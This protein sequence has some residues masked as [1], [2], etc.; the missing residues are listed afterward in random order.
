MLVFVDGEDV[1]GTLAQVPRCGHMG[2]QDEAAHLVL[3]AGHALG[4]GADGRLQPIAPGCDRARRVGA[5][6]APAIHGPFLHRDVHPMVGSGHRAERRRRRVRI[7][8]AALLLLLSGPCSGLDCAIGGLDIACQPLLPP[9]VLCAG[10]DHHCAIRR[11]GERDL[12]LIG[13]LGC[14]RTV[15]GRLRVGQDTDLFPGVVRHGLGHEPPARVR[16]GGEA[17]DKQGV[18]ECGALVLRHQCGIG[19]IDGSPCC[20]AMR[21]QERRDVC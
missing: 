5:G 19:D 12:A 11:P 18:A 1:P 4:L 2:E 6:P 8:A 7:G 20:D 3:Q 14:D 17:G 15:L 9:L 13:F 21:G 16:G 10:V